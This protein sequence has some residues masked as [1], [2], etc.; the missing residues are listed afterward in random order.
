MGFLLMGFL[1]HRRA[2]IARVRLAAHVRCE[3]RAALRTDTREI[4]VVEVL[5]SI[6][7]IDPFIVI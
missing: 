7:G 6:E 5:L 4:I 3:N 2:D 1:S